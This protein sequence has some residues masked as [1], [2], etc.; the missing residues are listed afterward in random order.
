MEAFAAFVA[1]GTRAF[2]TRQKVRLGCAAIEAMVE[3]G[4]V[5]ETDI[6]ET[7]ATGWAVVFGTAEGVWRDR[8]KGR[9]AV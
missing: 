5:A 3:A 9:A 6:R 8:W 2:A 1:V 4:L 7:R